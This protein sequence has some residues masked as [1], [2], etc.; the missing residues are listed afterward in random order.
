MELVRTHIWEAVLYNSVSSIFLQQ[1]TDFRF[2][3]KHIYC[4]DFA[5]QSREE[6][7]EAVSQLNWSY[8]WVQ[9]L[10]RCAELCSGRSQAAL[11]RWQIRTVH[12]CIALLSTSYTH[13]AA[14]FLSFFSSLH[15][16]LRSPWQWKCR[17]S[18]TI[19]HPLFMS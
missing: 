15:L 13:C 14:V 19:N 10:W 12:S 3:E 6:A 4:L 8:S 9:I 18:A 1:P 5:W 7:H 2:E 16:P 17:L 11:A